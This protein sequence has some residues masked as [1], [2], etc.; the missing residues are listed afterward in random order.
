MRHR[1]HALCPYFAMFPE[2]FVEKWVDLLSSPG[3]TVVD[4]FCGRGTTPFQALLQ[5]REALACDINP[6][7]YCVTRAKSNAPQLASV[8]RRLSVLE[9]SYSPQTN[10]VPLPEFFR[11]AYHR[12]T[13]GQ[14]TYLRHTLRWR[15]SRVDNMIA[16]L[17]LGSLHGE[18]D[19]ST[20]Y[21]SNQMPRTISTKPA[22]SVRFWHERELVA[23]KRDVFAILRQR[24]AFRY[25]S[26]APKSR[27]RVY[28]CDMRELPSLLSRQSERHLPRLAITSPPYFDVTSFE[29]DQWLRLWFLGG[30]PEPHVG[31]ISRDD[32]HYTRG[33]YWRLIA[34][35]WRVLGAVMD[36]DSHIVIRLGLKD[37]PPRELVA[38]LEGC[39]SFARRR[40]SLKSFE[41]SDIRRRQTD[42]FRP[43]SVGCATEVDCHFRIAA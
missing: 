42:A 34:D 41:T 4:P 40:V 13:L 21:F 27:A 35:M 5:G 36:S 11:V 31:R 33:G 1:F 28:N 14:I 16:A 23:P 2:T 12:R 24:A 30:P 43:G 6:V 26:E 20:A 10:D 37:V 17:T 29:E 3:D 39:S 9:S 15:S 32:R 8:L 19:K 38:L 18:A 22:Y 7:A 25:A